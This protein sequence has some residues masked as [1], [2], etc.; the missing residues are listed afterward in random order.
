MAPPG[1][2]LRCTSQPPEGRLPSPQ[3]PRTSIPA[4]K[5]EAFAV[6]PWGEL[7]VGNGQVKCIEGS[8]FS[9]F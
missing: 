8:V 3:L 5:A 2:A 1:Q 6:K 9:L 7:D 4:Q